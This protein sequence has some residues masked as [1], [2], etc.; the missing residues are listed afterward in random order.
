MIRIVEIED[1][2]DLKSLEFFVGDDDPSAAVALQ[3]LDDTLQRPAI[4]DELAA[5]PRRDSVDVDG[6]NLLPV[7]SPKPSLCPASSRTGAAFPT[8]TS[9]VPW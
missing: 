6:A 1:A 3:F 4:E 2:C 8:V 7:P 5:L 9:T